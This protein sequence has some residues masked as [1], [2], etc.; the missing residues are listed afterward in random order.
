MAVPAAVADLIAGP[1]RVGRVLTRLSRAVVLVLDDHPEPSGQVLTLLAPG[2]SGTPHGIRVPVAAVPAMF[3]HAVPGVPVSVGEGRVTLPGM[4]LRAARAVPSRVP[5]GPV[6]PDAVALLARISTRRPPGAGGPAGVR[7]VLDEA[8]PA[9]AV[10]ELLGLGPGL[11]PAGDDLLAGLLCGLWATGRTL[12]AERIGAVVGALA[13]A[14]TTAL[15]ADLLHQ[16]ARGHAGDAVLAVVAAVRAASGPRL[17]D[18]VA[19]LLDI[20]H[21]SGADLLAG[22][23]VGLSGSPE[24][25]PTPGR[26]CPPQDCPPQD[27]KD[28]R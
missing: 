7:R 3:A 13:P 21:T 23:V 15:S 2:A 4:S 10:L 6:D 20:G 25:P 11:T 28:G 18:A 17:H 24:R 12:E 1:P 26:L 22:L 14:R 9:P 8:D 19:A 27:G 5:P 16:A